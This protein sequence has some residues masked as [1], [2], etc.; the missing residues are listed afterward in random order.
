M[1]LP[2]LYTEAV[3]DCSARMVDEV[4][5]RVR[6]LAGTGPVVDLASGRGSL[7]TRLA[8]I[9]GPVVGTDASIRVLR[10][11]RR[12]LERL[13]LADRVSLI[14]AD[15]RHIPF[16]D[17]TIGI[18]TT[19]VGLDNLSPPEA[20]DQVL[21]ECRRVTA[22]PFLAICQAEVTDDGLRW[23]AITGETGRPHPILARLERSGWAAQIVA[24]GEA[25][26]EPTPPSTLLDGVHIDAFP[27]TTTRVEW[28]IVV[29]R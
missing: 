5:A 16:R 29:A 15:M 2:G 11:D 25:V 1:A 13:G 8:R 9:G 20:L 21:S 23:P 14:A 18:L 17:A 24:S 19:N 10:R 12:E 7:L 3:R 6:D 27:Q 28:S 4:A 26:A 22:G